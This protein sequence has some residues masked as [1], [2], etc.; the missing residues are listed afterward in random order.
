MGLLYLYLMTDD[1]EWT[2]V[3][4]WTNWTCSGSEQQKGS[5]SQMTKNSGLMLMFQYDLAFVSTYLE[6]LSPAFLRQRS[7]AGGKV[8]S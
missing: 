8:P 6:G 3:C 4:D 2:E 5:P 1:I 7:L